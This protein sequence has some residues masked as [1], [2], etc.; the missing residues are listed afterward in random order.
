MILFAD[1]IVGLQRIAASGGAPAPV[2][3]IDSTKGEVSHYYPQF[4]PGG[5]EFLY[6]VRSNGAAV[7][8]IYLG[9]L[10]GKGPVQILATEFNGLYDA[11]SGRLLYI[12]ED[13]NLM[14]RKLELNPPRLSGDPVMVAQ[15]V[16]GVGSNGYAQFSI[17][18]NGILF[19]GRGVLA[20]K[21]RFAWWD[22]TGKRLESIGKFFDG[23]LGRF[24][25]SDDGNRVA[26]SDGRP[27]DIWVMPLAS[28]I[29]TRVSFSG[30]FN[31]RWSHDGKQIYYSNGP[32][33]YRKASDGSGSEELLG[34][35]V[36]DNFV[37][38][39]SPDGGRLLF[40]LFDIQTL[41]LAERKKPEAYLQTKFNE[42]GA[43]FSPDGRWVA[44][45]S[46][47]SGRSEIY[48]QGFPE[49]RGKWQI[50]TEGA[51]FPQWRADGKELYWRGDFGASLMTAPI[52]LQPAGVKGG[53]PERMFRLPAREFAAWDGKRFLIVE[54]E[55]GEEQA[56]PMAV[57]TNWAAGLGK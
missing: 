32:A 19:H 43:V 8:G 33:I 26:Y 31:P 3:K 15:G 13:G 51:Q 10:D 22:R 54:P 30:G 27:A 47:E 29:G 18:A 11:N 39:V 56:L 46:D 42:G 25:L 40:G 45:H 17:S 5:K 37:T 16:S 34:K 20:V 55:G 6:L 38:S 48:I 1:Q 41:P 50:S 52:E 2:T 35:D 36:Q 24:S 53:R 28:G 14:A 23:F 44:Y 4:L 57:V 49:S 9:S 21:R 12:Q 7:T